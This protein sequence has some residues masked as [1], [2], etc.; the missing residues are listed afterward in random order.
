[1]ART[2]AKLLCSI[3]SDEDFTS[4]SAGAQRLFLLVISQPKLSI[5]GVID[6]VP[7]RWARTA[8]G[9]TVEDVEALVGE[10]EEHGYVAVDRDHAELLIRSFV[11]NDG[12]CARW[13]MVKAMWSAWEATSSPELR[14]KVL[15]NLPEE[16]WSVT[17]KCEPPRNAIAARL[18]MRFRPETDPEHLH[19][20]LQPASASEA[21]PI[22][23]AAARQALA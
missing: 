3:W 12:V 7:A 19:T 2:H 10:L 21:M 8:P 11:K 1:M 17:D 22:G 5:C 4:R 6:Y 9:M 16:A 18:A 14:L 23:I 15:E 13:Q 20:H